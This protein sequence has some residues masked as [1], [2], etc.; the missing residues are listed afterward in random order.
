MQ[1]WGIYPSLLM[2]EYRTYFEI[3]GKFKDWKSK[4]ILGL[5]IL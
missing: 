2:S 1:I 5:R 4:D 3:S